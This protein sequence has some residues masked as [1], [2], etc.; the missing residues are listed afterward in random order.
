MTWVL[1]RQHRTQVAVLGAILAVFA[2]LMAI[3]GNQMA[4]DYEA[5]R[6]CGDCRGFGLTRSYNLPRTVVN[7][8]VGVPVLLG[9]FLGA[10]MMAREVE[11]ATNVLAWT[12]S[13]TRRRWL[14]TKLGT[15][16]L[17]T[18]AIAGGMAALVTWWSRTMNSLQDYRFEALQFDIQNLSPVAYSLFAVALGFAA[19]AILR[20]MLPAV[21]VTVGGFFAVRL[22]IELSVRP[23]Y[24]AARDATF[25][26]F[27]PTVRPRGAWMVGT[28]LLDGNGDVVRG[29]LRMPAACRAAVDRLSADQCVSKLGYKVVSS[30]HPADRYWPFQWIEAGIFVALAALLV[31]VGAM[32]VLRRDA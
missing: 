15:V 13:V 21:G 26:L 25:A 31:A 17:I 7:L 10:A 24:A 23:H 16:L 6:H 20:R 18:V 1:W 2:V 29:P 8:S 3:T 14:A 28:K 32:V 9:V 27:A 19:A 12:Q 5:I 22:F 4:H 11:Q 30:F